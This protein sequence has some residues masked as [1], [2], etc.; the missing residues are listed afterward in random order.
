MTVCHPWVNQ[1]KRVWLKKNPKRINESVRAF[2]KA[3]PYLSMVYTLFG[4]IIFFGY[5]GHWADKHWNHAP[6]LLIAGV[7]L[8]FALGLYRMVKVTKNMNDS[9]HG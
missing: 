2:Q 3:A 5:L 1:R 8:G 9:N 7:F 4:A 6:L